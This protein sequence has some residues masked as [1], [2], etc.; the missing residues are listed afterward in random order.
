MSCNFSA[1]VNGFLIRLA[2]W[3]LDH[4][5][6][7]IVDTDSPRG[8][9][10]LARVD[11]LHLGDDGRVRSAIWKQRQVHWFVPWWSLFLYQSLVPVTRNRAGMFGTRTKVII[12]FHSNLESVVTFTNDSYVTVL[13]D[14]NRSLMVIRISYFDFALMKRFRVSCLPT[15]VPFRPFVLFFG[16]YVYSRLLNS[17][18]TSFRI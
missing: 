18:L 12:A 6:V 10:P 1:V 7:W 5:L 11:K 17:V 4:S 8:S 16:F 2:P 15:N 14:V 13:F 3:W 9:Y